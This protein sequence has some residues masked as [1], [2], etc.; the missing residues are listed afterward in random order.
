MHQVSLP[1]VLAWWLGRTGETDWDNV[2]KAADYIVANGPSSDNSAG[3]TREAGRRTRSRPRSPPDL[4]RHRAGRAAMRMDQGK[5]DD[6]EALADSWAASVEDW[7]ATDNGPYWPSPTTCGSPSRCRRGQ[8]RP[9]RRHALRARRQL[10]PQRRFHD[11]RRSSTTRS[12]GSCCSVSGEVKRDQTVLNSLLVGDETSAYPLKEDAERAGLAPLHVRRLRRA[13]NERL[14]P[15]LRQLPAPDARAAVA[16]ADGR[17]RRVRADRRSRRGLAPGTIANTANDGLMLPEQVWDDAAG[18]RDIGQGHA[19]GDAAGVDA[20]PVRVARVVD[21][22]GLPI[23]R[24]S[25]VACR[26]QGELCP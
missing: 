10:Q 5:A 6:Y 23:E 26:Y 2:E 18:R 16:A 24:P 8:P 20:R 3:R 9:E 11:Q 22:R 25:I 1:I 7:T 13:A 17:A 14:G 4:R 19:L 21:R 12:S 15:V